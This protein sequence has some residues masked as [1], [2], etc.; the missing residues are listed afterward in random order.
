MADNRRQMT[1]EEIVAFWTAINDILE[2][3]EEL[4]ETIGEENYTAEDIRVLNTLEEFGY[5]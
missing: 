1:R 3:G 5:K 2:D 4:I